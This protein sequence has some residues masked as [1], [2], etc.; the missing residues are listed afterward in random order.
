MD[1]S[2][3]S[4]CPAGSLCRCRFAP[5][6][7]SFSYALVV[8]GYGHTSHS[9]GGPADSRFQKATCPA[10]SGT[11]LPSLL[12]ITVYYLIPQTRKKNVNLGIAFAQ[13]FNALNPM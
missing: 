5:R 2:R 6:S 9:L 1:D 7:T 10:N 11:F 4:V 8:L 3:V 12:V 13:P